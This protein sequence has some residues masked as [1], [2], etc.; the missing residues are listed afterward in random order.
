[1]MTFFFTAEATAV[2]GEAGEAEG[3]EEVEGVEEAEAAE[4][5]EEDS[6]GLDIVA[7]YALSGLSLYFIFYSPSHRV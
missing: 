2:A 4:G 3:V 6:N 1:M 7:V 5:V